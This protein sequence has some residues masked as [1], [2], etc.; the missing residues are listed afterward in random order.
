MRE[1][2]PDAV[3]QAALRLLPPAPRLLTFETLATHH[4]G[5]T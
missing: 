2:D 3:Y 5:N 1:L 4:V